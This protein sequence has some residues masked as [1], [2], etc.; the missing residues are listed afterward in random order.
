MMSG[1]WK[2]IPIF[3]IG[4]RHGVF[5]SYFGRRG[6]SAAGFPVRLDWFAG[7]GVEPAEVPETIGDL[8]DADGRPLSDHDAISTTVKIK[9]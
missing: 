6:V 8:F 7:R 2:K 4:C 1:A 9:E 5:R 3:A